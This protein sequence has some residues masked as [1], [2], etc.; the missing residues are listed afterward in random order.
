MF[1]HTL[2]PPYSLKEAI[3]QI[4]DPKKNKTALQAF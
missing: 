3:P 4:G 2:L 1:A